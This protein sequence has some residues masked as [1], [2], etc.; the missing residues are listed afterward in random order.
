MK[1]PVPFYTVPKKHQ[2]QHRH[3]NKEK[4]VTIA[5]AGN[6]NVGKSAIFNQLTGLT[7]E[8]G[9]WTGK[10]VEI[11]EGF[12][13][14]HH[15]QIKIVDLPGIYS[16]S[17]YS[18]E[19]MTTREYILKERPDIVVNIVDA[20]SLERNLYLTLQLKEMAVP[21][22]I[23]LNYV[24][25]AKKKH[26]NINT[27]MLS[28]IIGAPV[29]GTVAIR[30]IG[31]HELI[32][33]ALAVAG[34]KEKPV[35]AQNLEYGTEVENRI[36]KLETTL[37]DVKTEQSPRWTAIKLLEQD[38]DVISQINAQNPELVGFSQTL[39][40]EL[41]RI[42]GEDSPS[43]IAAERYVMAAKIARQISSNVEVPSRLSAK[44]DSVSLHPVVGYLM[45]FAIMAAILLFV[46]FF[47]EWLTDTI[48]AIFT[49]LDP[50]ASGALADIL[51]NGAIVGF[52]AAI[53]VALGFILP[54]Y[55]IL[56][57]LGESGYLP[58]IAFLMDR[59]CHTVGLHGKASLP[60]ITAFGCN[61]PACMACRIM[62]NKR[63]RLIATFLTTMVPCSARIAVILG[64][65]GAFIGWQWAL[66][67]LVFQFL[68]IFGAGRVLNKLIPSTSP[69][70]ILEIPE[71]RLPSLKIVWKQAWHRF[72]DF[73]FIGVPLIVAG[74]AVIETLRVFNL[75]DS[76]TQVLSPITVYWLGLPAFTGVILIF[77]ILRKEATLALLITL[78]GGA[79]ITS[80]ISPLQMVVF[81][82]V[83]MI[84][85]P[86]LP[87]IA[88]LIKET[89][90]KVAL[91]IVFAEI[92]LAVLIGGLAAR[93]LPLIFS[94]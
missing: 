10:T 13:A 43:V 37:T 81:T 2:H 84:Y 47:G 40:N 20:T 67:L 92:M 8:I 69:G 6:A 94:F 63:D 41:S 68:L 83:I 46:S 65:V 64:M 4:Y 36:T 26:I 49:A 1:R 50:N 88:V 85:I 89:G 66:G 11:R 57:W 12:L 39:S 14:H 80:I 70:I 23:A 45:F 87:T 52:Y 71:Y 19:E 91:A 44:L 59:P 55:L 73:L 31:V 7:Q 22:V 3:R 18:P 33:A 76:I 28:Q 54:F 74:S 51:W 56:S 58:R 34:E 38:N 86:C 48:T 25:I 16:L 93:L 17:A 42:H 77:G 82:I 30:G 90:I 5:L 60:L 79:A 35:N 29:I 72:K 53:S 21:M 15:Q 61:V 24:D 75:L 9:N 27:D 32:D 62:E 78:A